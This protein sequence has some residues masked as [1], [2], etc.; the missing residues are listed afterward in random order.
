MD[1]E[2]DKHIVTNIDVNVNEHLDDSNN[3]NEELNEELNEEEKDKWGYAVC[4][5]TV[6]TFVSNFLFFQ[7]YEIGL[8]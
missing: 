4:F 6:I 8:N 7:P 1:C 5:G 3:T 2:I